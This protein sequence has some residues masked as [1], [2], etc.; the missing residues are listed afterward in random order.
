MYEEYPE[1]MQITLNRLD[2]LKIQ[3]IKRLPHLIAALET[4]I[5]FKNLEIQVNLDW[6]GDVQIL[7]GFI[8]NFKEIATVLK[9]LA[10]KGYNQKY[11]KTDRPGSNSIEYRFEGIQMTVNF[12]KEEGS[13]KFVQT[14]TKLE[15]TEISELRCN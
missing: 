10:K 2:D 15:E 3:V 11:S 1:E 12:S 9:W 8:K 7:I 4:K 13:C 6:W 14:G 5:K